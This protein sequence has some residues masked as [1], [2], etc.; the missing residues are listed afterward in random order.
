MDEQA[1]RNQ[2][3]GRAYPPRRD[4]ILRVPRG[5][6]KSPLPQHAFLQ[7]EYRLVSTRRVR[8]TELIR[9]DRVSSVTN[10]PIDHLLQLDEPSRTA[11]QEDH[12]IGLLVLLFARQDASA[13]P[14]PR[15]PRL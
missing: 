3:D 8:S 6:T 11:G 13:A 1:L 4:A 10:Q 5:T 14:K 9:C 15:L 7:G 12:G 2:L